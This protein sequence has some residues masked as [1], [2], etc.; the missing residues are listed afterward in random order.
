MTILSGR[1]LDHLV[2]LRGHIP[3]SVFF[4]SSMRHESKAYSHSRGPPLLIPGTL[5]Q[6]LGVYVIHRISP[7]I[8]DRY[9]GCL[10]GESILRA[11]LVS[12]AMIT[13]V[14]LWK[15]LERIPTPR[16]GPLS[17]RSYPRGPHKESS[18]K[19]L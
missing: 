4:L 6:S 14:K 1:V 11:C 17:S 3:R 13:L 10:L 8:L 5:V 9:R 16:S 7:L 19:I 15:R 18:R 2:S 12:K